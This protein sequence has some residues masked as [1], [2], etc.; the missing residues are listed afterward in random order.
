MKAIEV[1]L[2]D[3]SGANEERRLSMFLAHRDLRRAF[4]DI[5]AAQW[6]NAEKASTERTVSAPKPKR[7][8]GR[9]AVFCRSWL[10]FCR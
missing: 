9:A 8:L 4:T 3:Y 10:R 1:L 5:D 6:R 7:A 2:E